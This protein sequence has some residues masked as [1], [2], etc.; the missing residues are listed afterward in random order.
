MFPSINHPKGPKEGGIL[1]PMDQLKRGRLLERFG[2]TYLT[3][4]PVTNPGLKA[5]T[6][7][8]CIEAGE[9]G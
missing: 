1:I 8:I 9:F 4:P 3:L 2:K 5:E 6:P 7:F